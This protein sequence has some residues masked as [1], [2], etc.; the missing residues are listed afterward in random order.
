MGEGGGAP[1]HTIAAALQD[2]LHGAGIIVNESHHSA[3]R[4][5]ERIAH[6]NRAQVVSLTSG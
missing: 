4:L 2:A 3:P 5:F 1:L 6:P